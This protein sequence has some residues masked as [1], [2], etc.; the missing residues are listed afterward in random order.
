V[1]ED[2]ELAAEVRSMIVWFDLVERKVRV[3]PPALAAAIAR[4]PRSE[5]YGVL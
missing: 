1:K 2:G 4:L 3:P 5:D